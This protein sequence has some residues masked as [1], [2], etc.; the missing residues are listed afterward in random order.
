MLTRD[1]VRHVLTQFTGTEWHVASLL[2]SGGLRL[3]RR[4]SSATHLLQSGHDI[5]SIQE[6]LGHRAVCTTIIHTHGL[7]TGGPVLS[8]SPLD[9]LP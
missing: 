7:N 4:H 5:R 8:G 3:L 2:Y 9:E 1:D 6:V